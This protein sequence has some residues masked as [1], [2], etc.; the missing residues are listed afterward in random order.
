MI[1]KTTPRRSPL[2]AYL[3]LAMPIMMGMLTAVFISWGDNVMVGKLGEHARA[4][5][6]LANIIVAVPFLFVVGFTSILSPLVATALAAGD[7]RKATTTLRDAL[8]LTAAFALAATALLLFSAP[9]IARLG[10][11]PQVV[12][13]AQPYFAVISL[14]I[15]PASL[16]N[17]LKNYLDTAGW[18]VHTMMLS[19]ASGLCNVL[20]NYLLIYGKL[21][22]PALGV[23]GA[24]YATLCTRTL[25]LGIYA[26]YVWGLRRRG[27]LTSISWAAPEQ[28]KCGILLRLGLP[29]ALEVAFKLAYLS[30]CVVMFGWISVP[31]QASA[32]I[33][34]DFGRLALMIPIALAR[35]A[36]ILIGRVWGDKSEAQLRQLGLTGYG[37][38]LSLIGTLS[39][40]LYVCCPMILARLHQSDPVVSQAVCELLPLVSAGFILNGCSIVGIGLLRGMRDTLFPF[41][42][43]T[44]ACWLVGLPLGYALAF[45]AGWGVYGIWTGD[46]IGYGLSALVVSL[47]FVKKAQR[48]PRA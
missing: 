1:A 5:T 27:Q 28:K 15:I 44:M 23:L 21:G 4:A 45:Y 24:G 7:R 32:S 35:A 17:V 41:L 40:V 2:G 30:V 11:A 8:W 10:Q 36:S 47:R 26:S 6:A 9:W 37:T 14:S 12:Q 29:S 3:S 33:L 42:W 19:V 46:V 16:Y 39:V 13:L 34:M 22:L 31:A 38:T 48:L 25:F 43:S 18:V 20:G